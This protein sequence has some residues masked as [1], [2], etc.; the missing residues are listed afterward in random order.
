MVVLIIAVLGGIGFWGYKSGVVKISLPQKEVQVITPSPEPPTTSPT[1]SSTP[2]PTKKPVVTK[3]P[4]PK[5]PT[6]TATNT[7]VAAPS[8]NST[9]YDLNSATGAIQFIFNPSK[10]GSLYWT[11]TAEIKAKNGCKV[12]DGKSTDTVQSIKS[13]S[14]NSLSIPGIPPGSYEVRYSYH[15]VWS[16]SQTVS[17]STG[18]QTN[19]TFSVD[20]SSDP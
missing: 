15:Y 7:P 2:T 18:Q 20:N 8:C 10:G 6:P 13:S 16:S 1:I 19:V 14:S 9:D 3:T 5:P 17:V 12:L 11:T 4:T